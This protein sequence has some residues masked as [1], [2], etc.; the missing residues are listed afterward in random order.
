MFSQSN[1]PRYAQP[2]T[3]NSLRYTIRDYH[4]NLISEET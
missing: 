4:N 1:I 3:N 2:V